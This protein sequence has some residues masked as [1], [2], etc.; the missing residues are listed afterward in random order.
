MLSFLLLPDSGV[1][2]LAGLIIY[3]AVLYNG[4]QLNYQNMD[5]GLLF[6]PAIGLSEYRISDWRILET[7]AD[8][9]ISD[10]GL[11]LSDCRIS[12]SQK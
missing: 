8:F 7:I 5:I 3:C 4:T 6:F 10:R 2:I 12:D 9:R 1:L 11:N